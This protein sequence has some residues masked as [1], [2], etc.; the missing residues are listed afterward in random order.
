[1]TIEETGDTPE[2]EAAPEIQEEATDQVGAEEASEEEGEAKPKPTF[3]DRFNEV[4]GQKKAAEREA[5]ELRQRIQY[6]ESQQQAAQQD[7]APQAEE[8]P[9]QPPNPDQ[10]QDGTYDPAYMADQ[11][12]YS[13]DLSAYKVRQV[14]R[15]NEQR[16]RQEQQA[17]TVLQTF[18]QKA[19]ELG[20]E[21]QAALRLQRDALSGAVPVPPEVGNVLTHAENGVQLAAYLDQNRGELYRIANLPGH[22]R[23]YELAKIEQSMTATPEPTAP[24]AKPF[25]TAD[26]KGPSG[27]K[28]SGWRSQAEYRAFREGRKDT[29]KR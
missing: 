28:T 13:A 1:M 19:S 18:Q 3:K 2:H 23:S 5:E 24:T 12:R 20:E 15:E 21:G 22:M 8:Q 26:G 4:Y 14:M 16:T 9:P 10:Y 11:A 25:P 17:N 29:A 6:Y 7:P 27:A